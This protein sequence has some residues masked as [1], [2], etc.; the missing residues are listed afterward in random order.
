MARAN[1]SQGIGR[2]GED[3]HAARLVLPPPWRELIALS[4]LLCAIEGAGGGQPRHLLGGDGDRLLVDLGRSTWRQRKF[5]RL[6]APAIQPWPL[7]SGGRGQGIALLLR[8]TAIL[9]SP[10]GREQ[11]FWQKLKAHFAV[12]RPDNRGQISPRSTSLRGNQTVRK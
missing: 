3:A 1:A 5:A 2:N 11:M 8:L 10:S 9:P 12:H 7:K 4:S 6:A